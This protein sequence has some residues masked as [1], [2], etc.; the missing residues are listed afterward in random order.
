MEIL[1]TENKR[2]PLRSYE[3]FK[4]DTY[5]YRVDEILEDIE[6]NNTEY[7]DFHKESEKLYKEL[8]EMIGEKGQKTLIHYADAELDQKGVELYALAKQVYK[9]LK[10][11]K[12]R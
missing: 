1:E 11:D 4:K 10:E 6:T 3:E 5:E 7:V 9:D 2:K 12:D 8:E